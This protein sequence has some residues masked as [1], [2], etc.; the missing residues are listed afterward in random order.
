[1]STLVNV[2]TARSGDW[3]LTATIAII[4]TS[5]CG[6]LSAILFLVYNNWLLYK[7]KKEHELSTLGSDNAVDKF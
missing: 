2:Y 5:V 4:A 1:M 3:S 7:V 6:G